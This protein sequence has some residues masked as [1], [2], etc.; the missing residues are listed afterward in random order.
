MTM[1]IIMIG[2]GRLAT[3]LALALKDAGHHLLQVCSPTAAHAEAL[4]TQVGAEAITTVEE[5]RSD[6]DVYILAV[7]DSI[8]ASLIP[9][10]CKGREDALFVHTAGSMPKDLFKGY[11]RHYGVFYPM[12]TFSKERRVDFQQIPIFLEADSETALQQIKTLA[13]SISGSVYELSSDDRRYLHLAA[14]FAC[15][16]VNHFFALSADV[17]RKV[18]LP[19]SVMLPLIDETTRKVHELSPV[20]AQTGPAVREDHN[21]M[22]AQ[23]RLLSDDPL[24]QKIYELMSE[25]IM[26]SKKVKK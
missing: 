3:Q 1:N 11:A 2:S 10:V 18:H 22:Q 16:F 6:A 19:F 5:L 7:K 26:K 8:L 15:N 9:V 21:V 25:S 13:S 14:V 4:A 17:L 24:M 23:S 20:D 12:Q